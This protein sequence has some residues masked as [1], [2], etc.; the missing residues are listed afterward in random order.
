MTTSRAATEDRNST[1][2]TPEEKTY[3]YAVKE[4]VKAIFKPDKGSLVDRIKTRNKQ[5]T[6][7][8]NKD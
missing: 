4:R 6:D 8:I 2:Y 7:T 5:E 3:G 1:N